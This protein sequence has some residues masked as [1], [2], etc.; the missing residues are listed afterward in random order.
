MRR[1]SLP[2]GVLFTLVLGLAASGC[3]NGEAAG[4]G[5]SPAGGSPREGRGSRPGG[6]A[7]GGGN[8]FSGG[9]FGEQQAAVPVEVVA[10]ERRAISSYLETNGA[11]EAE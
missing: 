6:G 3:R 2:L 11:L 10:V 7:P 9:G 1:S 5:D 4:A 8:G